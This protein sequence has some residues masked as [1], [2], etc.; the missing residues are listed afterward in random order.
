MFVLPFRVDQQ[1]LRCVLFDQTQSHKVSKKG[2]KGFYFYYLKKDNGIECDDWI[3]AGPNQT[4]FL[5]IFCC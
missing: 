4:F 5:S 2:L 3:K 1:L